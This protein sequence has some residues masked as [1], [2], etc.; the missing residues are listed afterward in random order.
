MREFCA[1]SFSSSTN[2]V[3]LR[4]L[5]GLIAFYKLDVERCYDKLAQCCIHRYVRRCLK[6]TST[7]MLQHVL[8]STVQYICAMHR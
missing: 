6:H 2:K 8:V 7:E 5:V 1:A 4:H 3:R